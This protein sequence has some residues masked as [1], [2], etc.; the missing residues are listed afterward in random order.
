MGLATHPEHGRMHRTLAKVLADESAWAEA[1]IHW[2]QVPHGLRE[3][4]DVWTVIGMARAYRLSDQPR[5]AHDLAK[6]AVESNSDNPM[7][8]EE[9]SLCR[10]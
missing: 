8:Q 3:S 9:I 1:L 7:L 10:P 6:R 2:E 5:V 4:A